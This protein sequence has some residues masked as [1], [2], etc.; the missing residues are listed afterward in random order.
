MLDEPND[1]SSISGLHR[2][3][4][5]ENQLHRVVLLPAHMHT[6]MY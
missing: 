5:G 1:L 3:V 6:H 4:E 2:K